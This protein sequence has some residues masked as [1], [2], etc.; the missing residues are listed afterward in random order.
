M[1][2]PIGE[3]AAAALILA[4]AYAVYGLTGFGS[5]VVAIPLLALFLPLKFA[6]TLVMLLDFVAGSALLTK[7]HRSVR[8]RELL[9]MVP[10]MGLGILAG[11]YLLVNLPERPL[12]L[13][14]GVFVVSYA[15]FA[16][17]H[18]SGIPR[19]GRVWGALLSTLGGVLA[20]LYNIGGVLWAVYTTS[21]IADKDHLRATT[22]ATLWISVLPRLGLYANAGLLQESELWIITAL[23]IAPTLI[24]YYVGQLLHS[25]L[26]PERFLTLVS[27]VLIASGCALILRATTGLPEVAP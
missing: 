11:V 21:R 4:A 13:A 26:S 15:I 6:V 22:A 20:A 14:L 2:L 5:S 23:L 27:M 24:G 7:H 9:L 18:R 10:F 12:I 25:R 1:T 16:L 8:F 19:L 3:L 17:T